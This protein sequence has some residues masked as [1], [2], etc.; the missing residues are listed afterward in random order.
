M[1]NNVASSTINYQEVV[2]HL[3]NAPR[4]VCQNWDSDSNVAEVVG[5]VGYDA[6]SWAT[7]LDLSNESSVSN[8]WIKQLKKVDL[9]LKMKVL[10][11]FEMSGIISSKTQ[12]HI[13]ETLNLK[14]TCVHFNIQ[15]QSLEQCINMIKEINFIFNTTVL[16]SSLTLILLTWRI[17]WAPKNASRWQMEFNSAFKGL[18]H[19]GMSRGKIRHK[20]S[21]ISEVKENSHI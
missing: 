7:V 1:Y 21:I 6:V 19:Q 8:F 14:W 16:F 15:W 5:V 17:W 2:W 10:C 12:C 4:N 18:T 9:T 13:P 11:S 3:T 20:H